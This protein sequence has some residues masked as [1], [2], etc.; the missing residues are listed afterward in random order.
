MSSYKNTGVILV[1]FFSDCF[2]AVPTG[3]SYLS[4]KNYSSEFKRACLY[5]IGKG[6]DPAKLAS[7]LSP[8]N[9]NFNRSMASVAI[10]KFTVTYLTSWV[11]ETGELRCSRSHSGRFKLSQR[12]AFSIITLSALISDSCKNVLSCS[13]SRTK[14]SCL[15][16]LSTNMRSSSDF[17]TFSVRCLRRQNRLIFAV[18][19]ITALN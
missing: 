1:K 8:H 4:W 6:N 3:T 10:S 9:H 12:H 19:W 18:W 13:L 17:V 15:V 5:F 2:A 16:R 11:M 7:S 14:K